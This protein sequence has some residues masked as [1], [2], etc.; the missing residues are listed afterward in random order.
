MSPPFGKS[1]QDFDQDNESEGDYF[2][3]CH[4]SC[5]T[6]DYGYY[7]DDCLSCVDQNKRVWEDNFSGSEVCV[8]CEEIEGHYKDSEDPIY[9]RLCKDS[10]CLYCATVDAQ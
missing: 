3:P 5:L 1:Y 10:N 6:C 2:G 4:P 7:D 8:I 9:C